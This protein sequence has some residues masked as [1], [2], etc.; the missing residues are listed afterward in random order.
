MIPADVQAVLF[1]M[2]GTLVDTEQ[3]T[4]AAVQAL[5]DAQGLGPMAVDPNG[6]FGVTW[7]AVADQV[8]NAHPELSHFDVT[9]ALQA[10][11]SDINSRVGLTLVPGSDEY[12]ASLAG[13]YKR[14][15]Y[16]SNIRLEVDRLVAAFPVF[17]GFDGIITGEVVSHSKPDPEGFILLAQALGV[18]PEHCVVFEDSVA[19][20]T[21]AK[22][23]GMKTIA[24]THRCPDEAAVRRIADWVV[25]D[26][27]DTEGLLP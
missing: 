26:F 19:G 11:F 3:H 13:R 27:K 22:A 16:T 1:D 2:D 23:A 6:L 12:F 24:V 15:L 10:Y 8:Q 18:D 17:A 25:A 20:L 14:G 9:P 7:E 21:G 5:L 4:A